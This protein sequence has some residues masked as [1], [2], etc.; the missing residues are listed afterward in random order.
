MIVANSSEHR[1]AFSLASSKGF[2]ACAPDTNILLFW[3]VAQTDI[4]LLRTFKRVQNFNAQDVEVLRDVLK[5]FQTIATTPHVLTEVSNFIDQA[6]QYRR[7]DLF[8]TF[9]D[10]INSNA[11]SYEESRILSQR[12]EF[13]DL[14]LADT[15]LSSLSSQFTVITMD[16]QLTGRIRRAG[17]A[18]INFQQVRSE[19]IRPQA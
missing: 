14:G 8:E 3:L 1:T 4:S 2:A 12:D 19:R 16:F 5:P 7:A 15:G 18:V 11:E 9:R 13:F 6:P 10:F 17:G